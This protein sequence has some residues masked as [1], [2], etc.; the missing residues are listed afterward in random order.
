[1]P[2]FRSMVADLRRARADGQHPELEMRL[3]TTNGEG[4][5][6]P[7]VT[8]TSFD[9][10][11]ADLLECSALT[12]DAGWS[13]VVD[14]Y[15]TSTD[16]CEHRTRVV[17]DTDDMRLDSG[18]V[19]KQVLRRM[20]CTGESDDVCRIALALET[21]TTPPQLVITTHV[22]I[23]QRRCFRDVR[24]GNVV[25]SYELSRVWS[26]A[27]YLAAEYQQHYA[28]PLYEVECELVDETGAYLRGLSDEE[29][30]ESIA[31]KMQ[32]LTGH[33]I[34]DQNVTE[35]PIRRSKKSERLHS[36]EER[37]RKRSRE[38]KPRTRGRSNK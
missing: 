17:A 4:R 26:A 13:E 19:S 37:Q 1:M 21:P 25:W 27:G 5:F 14:H 32:M 18:T 16:G 12:A 22:R 36:S 11:E 33:P 7:G 10:L 34:L 20:L 29:V 38:R 2:D 8:K 28:P 31:L 6:C 24:D 30:A 9:E 35:E 3:G 23:K 15:F